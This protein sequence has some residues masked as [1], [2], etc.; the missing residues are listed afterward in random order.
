MIK[1]IECEQRSDEWYRARM[2]I[3][4]A[5]KFDMILSPTGKASSQWERY[6]NQILAE[7]IAGRP[8]E[9]YQS[10]A[11]IEGQNRETESMAYYE[12]VNKVEVRRVGFIHDLPRTKGC[13]PD[14][15]VG[16]DGIGELKNPEPHTHVNYLL[17]PGALTKDY[18]S[19]VQG[20]LC[21]TE[22]Q[23][24]DIISYVPDLPTVIERIGRNEGY[25]QSLDHALRDFNMKLAVL[26]EKLINAG[27][28]K[29]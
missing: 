17:N 28:L 15:L 26:R 5:S 22:R 8:F 16:E 9:G 3:P 20:S 24:C 19:Q 27:H 4:T 6:V 10:A 18:V 12:M 2:G 25:I 14:F 23:W 7:E 1:I 11:M 21:V 29:A 13:S